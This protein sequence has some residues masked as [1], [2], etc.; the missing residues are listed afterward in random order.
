MKKVDFFKSYKPG[1]SLSEYT[2]ILVMMFAIG[3]VALTF[4]SNQ[5]SM[6]ANWLG[7]F[8]V[9]SVNQANTAASGAVIAAP[10]P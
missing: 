5:F 2:L 6:M 3:V 9:N 7:N 4:L 8:L 1:V 10:P